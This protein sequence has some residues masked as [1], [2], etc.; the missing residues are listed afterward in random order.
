MVIYMRVALT[1]GGAGAF[2]LFPSELAEV[3]SS[4]LMEIEAERCVLVRLYAF[5]ELGP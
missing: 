2:P 1:N 3:I 5:S 4:S